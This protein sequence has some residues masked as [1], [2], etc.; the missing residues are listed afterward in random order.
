MNYLL[1]SYSILTIVSFICVL[2]GSKLLNPDNP[3]FVTLLY[4]SFIVFFLGRLYEVSRLTLNLS[5]YNV[6]ELG[7]IGIIGTFSFLLSSNFEISTEINMKPNKKIKIKSILLS[8][9]V[10]LMYFIIL[11]GDVSVQERIT[12]LIMVIYASYNIYYFM[13]HIMLSKE[14][15][16]NLLKELKMYNVFGII[17]SIL[18]VLLLVSFSYNFYLLLFIVNILMSIDMLLMMIFFKKGVRECKLMK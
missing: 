17:F 15:Q 8:I 16:S 9:V 1:I 10:G 5:L 18:I 2:I 4:L 14:D 13:R 7:F 6:F 12:D 11:C 3:L